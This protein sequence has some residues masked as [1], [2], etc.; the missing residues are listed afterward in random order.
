[1]SVFILHH[2]EEFLKVV[3]HLYSVL[4]VACF[5]FCQPGGSVMV[6]NGGVNLH[7]RDDR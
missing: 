4:F 3:Y 7:S 5:N 6:F 1:M 2:A